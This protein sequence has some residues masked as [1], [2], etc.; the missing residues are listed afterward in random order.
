MF[1]LTYGTSPAVYYYYYYYYYYYMHQL[2]TRKGTHSTIGRYYSVIQHAQ[3]WWQMACGMTKWWDLRSQTSKIYWRLIKDES[4]KP[5]K[6][7]YTILNCNL[8]KTVIISNWNFY[9][10]NSNISCYGTSSCT[11]CVTLITGLG[12]TFQLYLEFNLN[13]SN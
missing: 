6:T 9:L 10:L 5:G 2:V 3:C 11:K 4:L 7:Y 8:K 13:L 1:S 12:Y